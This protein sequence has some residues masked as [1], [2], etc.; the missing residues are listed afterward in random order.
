MVDSGNVRAGDQ[1]IRRR[2]DQLSPLIEP[3][4][5]TEPSRSACQL[6]ERCATRRQVFAARVQDKSMEP[7]IPDGA[8]C[9]FRPPRPGSRQGRGV[10]CGTQVKRIEFSPPRWA[11][12]QL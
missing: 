1:S 9:L 11:N 8:Y 4:A 2:R 6:W 7:E 10:L 5:E 3:R 12:L